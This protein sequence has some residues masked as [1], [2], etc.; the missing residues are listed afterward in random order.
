MEMG[1]FTYYGPDES[2]TGEWHPNGQDLTLLIWASWESGPGPLIRAGSEWGF[3]YDHDGAVSYR[4][5]GAQRV[6]E[7][8]IDDLRN[9]WTFFALLTQRNEAT[10]WINE[11]PADV[12][13][14]EVAPPSGDLAVMEGAVGS[15]AHFAVYERRLS[16]SDLRKVWDVGSSLAG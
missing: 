7:I 2:V 12:W 9:R 10:L 4:V 6:T 1:Q 16:E 5:G 15:A 13:Q 14:T 8:D 3:P 11:G